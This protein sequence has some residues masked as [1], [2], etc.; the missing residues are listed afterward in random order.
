MSEN[1]EKILEENLKI[2]YK[3]SIITSILCIIPFVGV[4]IALIV[5]K[6]Y[7]N[8]SKKWNYNDA[9]EETL[10]LG[11]KYEFPPQLIALI[12]NGIWMVCIALGSFLL[13]WLY[14][15]YGVLIIIH[16]NMIHHDL[17]SKQRKAIEKNSIL[18][19]PSTSSS[20]PSQN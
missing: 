8:T 5:G 3:A 7:F 6:L 4:I 1:N 17:F 18:P 12:F 15:I 13:L 9:N 2:Y 11:K 16:V 14:I 10:A 20:S 19:P